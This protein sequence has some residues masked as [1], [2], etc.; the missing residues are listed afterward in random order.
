MTFDVSLVSIAAFTIVLTFLGIHLGRVRVYDETEL[1]KAREKP[2]VSFLLDLSYKRRIFEVVLDVL[3]ISLAYYLSYALKFGS[4]Q[5]SGD[6]QLFIQLGRDRWKVRPQH[7]GV[8]LV[9][10][11]IF[12][13][14]RDGQREHLGGRKFLESSCHVAVRPTV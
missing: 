13:L 10:A 2:L 14:Q 5:R 12:L 4:V 8:L 1:A 7:T 6:W 11:C 3:L 9:D